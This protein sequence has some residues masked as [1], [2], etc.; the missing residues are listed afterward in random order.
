VPTVDARGLRCPMPL[1][2]AKLAM[3]QLEPGER[4]LV[5][6][7]DPEAPI[8]LAAWAAEVGH[9]FGERAPGELELTKRAP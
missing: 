9:E 6:A 3:E 5:L 7:D 4:L 8:D 2:K 1:V